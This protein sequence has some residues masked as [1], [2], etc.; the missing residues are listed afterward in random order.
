[1]DGACGTRGE[2]RDAHRILVGKLR[3]RPLGRPSHRW[4]KILGRMNLKEIFS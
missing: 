4:E 2:N 1:M 3:E